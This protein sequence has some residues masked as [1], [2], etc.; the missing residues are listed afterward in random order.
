[1]SSNGYRP[2]SGGPPRACG[3]GTGLDSGSET[4][5]CTTWTAPAEQ[6]T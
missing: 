4:S 6:T 1:M 2:Q 5:A 3:I